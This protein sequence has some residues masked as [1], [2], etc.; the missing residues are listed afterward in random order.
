MHPFYEDFSTPCFDGLHHVIMG[1][2]FLSTGSEASIYSRF[3]FRPHF[4]QHASIRLVEQEPD[5]LLSSDTDAPGPYV[6]AYPFRRSLAGI[7]EANNNKNAS[8]NRFSSTMSKNFGKVSAAFSIPHQG[9]STSDRIRDLVVSA[10][11]GVGINISESKI[12][13]VGCGQGGNDS[14]NE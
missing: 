12:L 3:H 10:A 1:G 14:E 4:F 7:L 6:G 5:L 13:D 11:L 8:E 9:F 2:S